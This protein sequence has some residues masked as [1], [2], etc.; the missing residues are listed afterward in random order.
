MLFFHLA[1]QEMG[2]TLSRQ[3]V[4]VYWPMLRLSLCRINPVLSHACSEHRMFDIK[5]KHAAGLKGFMNLPKYRLDI[6]DVMKRQI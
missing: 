5:N 4:I 3:E 1:P 6:F 2:E